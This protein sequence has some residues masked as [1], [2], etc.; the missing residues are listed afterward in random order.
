MQ[1]S[2]LNMQATIL[3]L[4]KNVVLKKSSTSSQRPLKMSQHN[5]H[6]NYFA[7]IQDNLQ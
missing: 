1:F 7:A 2:E 3:H 4:S 6:V 5:Y